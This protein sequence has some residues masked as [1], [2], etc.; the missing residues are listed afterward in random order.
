MANMQKVLVASLL[1]WKNQDL[2]R[3]DGQLS[4]HLVLQRH[5]SKA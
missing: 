3:L 5:F 1:D 2:L 4:M